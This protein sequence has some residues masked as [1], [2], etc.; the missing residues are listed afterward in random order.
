MARQHVQPGRKPLDSH[1][2]MRNHHHRFPLYLTAV[3]APPPAGRGRTLPTTT[4]DPAAPVVKRWWL[5]D[6]H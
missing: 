6:D 5:A 1:G 2:A 3:V 4:E